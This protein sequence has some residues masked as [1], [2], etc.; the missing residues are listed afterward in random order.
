MR[1]SFTNNMLRR[2]QGKVYRYINTRSP[3]WYFKNSLAERMDDFP[4]ISMQ[5]V[6]DYYL[7]N[8]LKFYRFLDYLAHKS[9]IGFLV[10]ARGS[11]K[12]RTMLTIAERMKSTGKNICFVN[13]QPDDKDIPEG[14]GEFYET[15]GDCPENSFIFFDEYMTKNKEWNSKENKDNTSEMVVA[16][17]KGKSIIYCSQSIAGF[18]IDI[19]RLSD[20]GIYKPFSL[21]QLTADRQE[22]F[23]HLELFIPQKKE[24]VLFESNEF[25]S[26]FEIPLPSWE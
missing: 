14:L 10:G 26:F 4:E 23:R 25:C 5:I 7:D 15:V 2:N 1:Y 18:P 21:K 22:Y 17:H 13:F 24:Q 12:T 19:M 20:V 3:D 16:R 11:G 8:H 9:L 6:E